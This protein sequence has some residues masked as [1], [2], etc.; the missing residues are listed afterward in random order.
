MIRRTLTAVLVGCVRCYQWG[1]SPLLPPSCRFRPT[2]SQYA[3][4][5]MTTHGPWRGSVMAAKRIL[6]C[7]PGRPG[8]WDPVPCAAETP[9]R[10][11]DTTAPADDQP[12]LSP[13]SAPPSSSGFSR[14][15]SK[16]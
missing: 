2:C 11:P 12:S 16:R 10:V 13:V 1:V 15:S 3:A 14:W 8:G 5:A 6:R 4:E 9:R 7:R